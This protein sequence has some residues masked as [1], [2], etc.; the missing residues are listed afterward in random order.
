MNR[1]VDEVGEGDPSSP[2]TDQRSTGIEMKT[3][4]WLILGGLAACGFESVA[5]SSSDRSCMTTRTCEA[6]AG[7]LIQARGG[8]AGHAKGGS[9]GVSTSQGGEDALAGEGGV[10]D[11]GPE[12]TH[13]NAGAGGA[14]IADHGGSDS[15]GGAE[16]G[17]PSG[18]GGASAGTGGTG[19]SG[20]SIP[21]DTVPPTIL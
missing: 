11:E 8:A 19:G 9:S 4:Y 5:C 1:L 20:G 6:T 7:N 18:R 17:G 3:K 2:A 13:G 14:E 10:G 15:G 16:L 21:A 12:A